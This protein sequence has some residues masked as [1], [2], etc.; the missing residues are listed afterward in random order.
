MN[1]KIWIL[2]VLWLFAV[3]CSNTEDIHMS[4][5]DGVWHK[6][7][8]KKIEFEI[9]DAQTPKNITFVVRNNNDYPYN[10]LFLISS[11]KGSKKENIKTD[12]LNYIIAKPNGEWLGSGIGNVKEVFFQYKLHYKFPSNGKYQVE[13]KHGMRKDTLQGI[14]DI[15]IKIENTL[16]P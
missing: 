13:I 8:A 10:N 16:N 3:S 4:P 12:T 9:K 11:L 7:N 15:G 2:P 1:K 14:E 5:V 6:D